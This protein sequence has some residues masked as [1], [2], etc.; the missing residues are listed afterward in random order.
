[1]FPKST[2]ARLS[3]AISFALILALLAAL[4]WTQW[5]APAQRNPAERIGGPFELVNTE[6]E[7]VT[8]QELRGRYLLVFFGY[9]HCPDVCPTTLNA[10]TQALDVIGESQPA[11]AQRVTPVFVTIDPARDDV[12][13]M[14]DYVANFHSRTLGLTG[15][16]EQI[17]RAAK[18]YHVSYSK[19]DSAEMQQAQA[20][21][22]HGHADTSGG[23]AADHAAMDHGGY[24]MQ[25]SSYVFLMGP[26]G[27]HLAHV[28]AAAGAPRIAEMIR[29]HVQR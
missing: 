29:S 28:N 21:G 19:V 24:L 11:T 26:D 27:D 9:T 25:H 23:S 6:G 17:A 16:P 8:A 5:L 20:S 12:A 13:R 4:A 1:M 10:M 15:S 14:R 3:A 18:A 7:T 2:V 22:E